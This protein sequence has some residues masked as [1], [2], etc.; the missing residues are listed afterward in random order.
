MNTETKVA[1]VSVAEVKAALESGKVQV[2]DVRPSFDF[3]GGRIPGSMSLPNRSLASRQEQLD[4]TRRM[5][6]VS[7]H[8][9]DADGA[10]QLALTL[11]FTDVAVVEGGFDAWLNAGYPTQTI[12]DGT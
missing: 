1:Q 2:V 3:A 8:G 7:E 12:D 9:G 6:L 10:A 11:G 4:R 5:V